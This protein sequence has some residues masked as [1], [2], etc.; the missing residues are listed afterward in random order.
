MRDKER[1]NKRQE[2]LQKDNP[3][4]EVKTKVAADVVQ[5]NSKKS[6]DSKLASK[7][8]E[9]K[10]FK[11]TETKGE[12][13]TQTAFK[14]E[15]CTKNKSCS[16]TVSGTPAVSSSETKRIPA[17][18]ELD[19][20]PTGLPVFGAHVGKKQIF[21]AEKAVKQT[22]EFAELTEANL[23]HQPE[24]QSSYNNC[25]S[26]TV[27][28]STTDPKNHQRSSS[29]SLQS[30]PVRN[31]SF[32]NIDNNRPFCRKVENR[33]LQPSVSSIS[34]FGNLE[35]NMVTKAFPSDQIRDSEKS[36]HILGNQSSF[37][38]N[39][40]LTQ[41]G[42]DDGLNY[43]ETPSSSNSSASSSL[44]SASTQHSFYE[45]NPYFHP[46]APNG[47]E[48]NGYGM[49][50]YP[51]LLGLPPAVCCGPYLTPYNNSY[52]DFND[53]THNSNSRFSEDLL[54]SERQPLHPSGYDLVI[55]S[56]D[57]T[58]VVLYRCVV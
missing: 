45:M 36:L 1:Q 25:H 39:G 5:N 21:T 44:S 56:S 46:W 50:V 42:F 33:V 29:S 41:V 6:K 11:T 54:V 34:S 40:S 38:N 14:A 24:W 57:C 55:L 16:V 35:V 20:G 30:G 32:T 18:P 22:K 28:V 19:N 26:A 10:S 17:V 31:T 12:T 27:S 7:K 49:E 37:L 3:G 58:L 51:V 4:K 9:S 47:Y 48:G 15:L 43:A 13:N 52:L 2:R 8:K 53:L 23:P